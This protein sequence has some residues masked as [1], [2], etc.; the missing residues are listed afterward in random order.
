M[1]GKHTTTG[2]KF[3]VMERPRTEPPPELIAVERKPTTTQNN[4]VVC[5]KSL[6][7]TPAKHISHVVFPN[8]ITT[9]PNFA[10]EVRSAPEHPGNPVATTK[11]TTTTHIIVA[12]ERL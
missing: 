10:V 9:A 1:E 8:L 6:P 7:G 5:T 3:V 11:S 4:S 2:H 12:M